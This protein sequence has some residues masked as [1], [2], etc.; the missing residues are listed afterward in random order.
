MAQR[1]H[2]QQQQ[3]MAQQAQQQAQ[4]QAAAQ[5]PPLFFP[6]QLGRA[7]PLIKTQ[8]MR[9]AEDEALQRYEEQ[10]DPSLRVR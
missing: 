6:Q 4:A 1:Q 5:L 2:Q 7:G 8:Q 3:L 10:Q 9:L